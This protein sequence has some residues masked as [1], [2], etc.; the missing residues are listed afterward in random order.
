MKKLFLISLLCALM[1]FCAFA[2]DEVQ[3]NCKYKIGPILSHDLDIQAILPRTKENENSTPDLIKV[4]VAMD[5]DSLSELPTDLVNELSVKVE[6]LGGRVGD[7]AYNNV[8]VWL[9]ADKINVLVEWKEITFIRKPLVANPQNI[10]SEG[11]EYIGAPRWNDY[12]F[13]GEGVKVGVVD[14]GFKDFYFLKGTELPSSVTTAYTGTLGDF[15]SNVHGAACGEIIYDIAP[16]SE[17]FF[18]NACDIGVAFHNAVRWLEL[19]NVNVI[20]SSISINLKLMCRYLYYAIRYNNFLTNEIALYYL[21]QL[22]NLKKQWENTVKRTFYSGT[23]WVQSAGNDGEKQWSGFF[24]DYNNN[25]LLN[26]SPYEDVNAINVEGRVNED[27]YVLMRWGGSN[28][29]SYD[30]Y[31]LLIIDQYL[32]VIDVSAIYQR[33][34]GYGLEICKFTIQTGKKYYILVW[35]HPSVKAVPLTI[36]VGHDKF[37]SLQY[38]NPYGTVNLSCPAY[39]PEI[40]TVGAALPYLEDFPYFS[41]APYSSQGAGFEEVIKPDVVAP[42]GVTTASYPGSF[43]GTSAAAPHVAGLC[44]LIKQRYP[45]ASP[46]QIKEFLKNTAIDLGTIGPDNTYGSGLAHLPNW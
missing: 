25:N 7:N 29:I 16:A 2:T 8:Q 14:I 17:M 38:S 26:F 1:P 10:I 42:T 12:G 35:R 41:I 22:S 37:P 21:E 19:N 20:S 27:V 6:A 45:D 9:P 23:T 11:V 40:I 13:K 18:V 30:D 33:Y 24:M 28:L 36:F 32:N 4:I 46:L 15:Y 39:V 34:I 3:S 43:G 5:V 31:D 44:A